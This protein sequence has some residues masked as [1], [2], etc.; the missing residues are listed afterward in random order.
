MFL[1][2]AKPKAG[3]TQS[4][5][6]TLDG[7]QALVERADDVDELCVL[8]LKVIVEATEIEFR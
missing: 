4:H 5:S 3:E 6:P 2:K 8:S 1:L 7:K